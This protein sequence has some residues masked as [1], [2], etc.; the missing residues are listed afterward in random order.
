MFYSSQLSQCII[1][2]NVVITVP[3][4]GMAFSFKNNQCLLFRGP[5]NKND[6]RAFVG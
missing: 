2:D 3:V 5:N 1:C 4:F 6:M